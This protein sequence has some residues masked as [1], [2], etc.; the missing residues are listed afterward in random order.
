VFAVKIDWNAVGTAPSGPPDATRLGRGWSVQSADGHLQAPLMLSDPEVKALVAQIRPAAPVS[1]EPDDVVGHPGEHAE[2]NVTLSSAS[3]AKGTNRIQ[4]AI[5]NR[6]PNPAYQVA[7]HLRSSSPV[8]HGAY[9]AV[10]QIKPGDI[11]QKAKR[12]AALS[13]TDELD[14]MVTVEVTAWN[15]APVRASKRVQLAASKTP[16][17]PPLQLVCASIDKT[18]VPGQQVRIHCDV[19]NPNAMAVQ[20]VALQIAMGAASA[21]PAASAPPIKPHARAALILAAPAPAE[22]HAGAPLPI[23]ITLNASDAVPVQQQI[24]QPISAG[25]LC[26]QGKLTPAAYAAQHTRIHDKL[27]AGALSQDDFDDRDAELVNCIE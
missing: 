16:R 11:A 23:L 4:V 26:A 5:S 27:Q 1:D 22:A 10:G 13:A 17:P 8:I 7:V 9:V 14:P 18:V 3:D 6:G 2:L 24:V 25:V 19:T 21:V 20:G 12:L 15:A